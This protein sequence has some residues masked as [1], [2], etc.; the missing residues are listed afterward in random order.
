M[1]VVYNVK[2][3][4]DIDA[5]ILTQCSLDWFKNYLF[6]KTFY[7]TSYDINYFTFNNHFIQLFTP[8]SLNNFKSFIHTCHQAYVLF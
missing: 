5:Y 4:I 8:P 7:I 6:T 2:Y 1:S 3:L